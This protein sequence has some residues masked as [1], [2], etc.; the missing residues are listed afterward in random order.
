MGSLSRSPR[1]SCTVSDGDAPALPI[2]AIP[3][4]SKLDVRSAFVT[5]KARKVVTKLTNSLIGKLEIGA[6]MASMYLLGNPDHY[7]NQ[8]FNDFYWK[9]FVDHALDTCH[10]DEYASKHELDT[11]SVLLYNQLSSKS[12][13]HL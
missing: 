12:L 6:P 10:N 1:H 5:D 4:Y 11:A 13:Y 2:D 7:T 3:R 9:M 8:Q